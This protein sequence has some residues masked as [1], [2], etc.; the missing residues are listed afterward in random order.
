MSA[1]PRT[2]LALIKPTF[3]PTPVKTIIGIAPNEDP[4]RFALEADGMLLETEF[5]MCRH[6]GDRRSIEL[7]AFSTRGVRNSLAVVYLEDLP[8]NTGAVVPAIIERM[9]AT[10]KQAS[11]SVETTKH[12]TIHAL[13]DMPNVTKSGPVVWDVE[14][15]SGMGPHGGVRWRL[16]A[17]VRAPVA[18]LDVL[19][20]NCDAR[21]PDEDLRVRKFRLRMPDGINVSTSLEYPGAS[22]GG[23]LMGGTG[24]VTALLSGRH[25][26]F[27]TLL[28]IGEEES[29]DVEAVM[30]RLA[31]CDDIAYPHAGG[32]RSFTDV[33]S[34]ETIAPWTAHGD[35]MS[36]VDDDAAA[37]RVMGG[38]L[39]NSM[40]EALYVDDPLPGSTH[41]TNGRHG[42]IYTIGGGYGAPGGGADIEVRPWPHAAGGACSEWVMALRYRAWAEEGR[43]MG[44]VFWGG[45]SFELP[46]VGANVDHGMSKEYPTSLRDSLRSND[47][48]G[49]INYFLDAGHTSWTGPGK[50][51]GWIGGDP[52]G[53]SQLPHYTGDEPDAANRE[54][55]LR[56]YGWHDRQ[57]GI[58]AMRTLS[59]LVSLSNDWLARVTLEALADAYRLD[60]WEGNG[61]ELGGQWK[62]AKD[63]PGGFAPASRQL[64]WTAWC[65]AE[66]VSF[67]GEHGSRFRRAC[68]RFMETMDLG[69]IPSGWTRD[70]GWSKIAQHVTPADMQTQN[71]PVFRG[72]SQSWY[73]ALLADARMGTFRACRAAFGS[74]LFHRPEPHAVSALGWWFMPE[75]TTW[76]NYAAV[77]AHPDGPSRAS[78]SDVPPEERSTDPDRVSPSFDNYYHPSGLATGITEAREV[79]DV[80]PILHAAWMLHVASGG[81]VTGWLRKRKFHGMDMPLWR[82]CEEVE[83]LDPALWGKLA[84]AYQAASL[85]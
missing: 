74:L 30:N 19:W 53:F 4:A 44:L 46:E 43:G 40:E 11:I 21:D 17:W 54:K 39:L 45:R 71:P 70:H 22:N 37:L 15:G 78:L 84:Q 64:A 68:S 13:A 31:Y 9:M 6:A 5:R 82:L 65:W 16:R 42:D 67:L 61:G 24:M 59:A 10:G 56:E 76:L 48:L 51:Q 23:V 38:S 58:L 60:C 18:K 12:E 41:Q 28:T 63:G 72:I 8:Q 75:N 26:T 62:Q 33:P 3:L 57:H 81:D 50:A 25:T 79:G 27:R 34:S 7:L 69:A 52:F 47:S 85:L 66:A 1:L 77:A 36:I 14:G 2:E 32:E 73:A 29:D 35:G 49:S 20:H 80:V 55:D 83:A